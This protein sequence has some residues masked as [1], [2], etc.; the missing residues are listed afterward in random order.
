MA[1]GAVAERGAAALEDAGIL[2]MTWP[3][4]GAGGS[5]PTHAR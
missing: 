3:M 5:T 2:P 4:A 1:G